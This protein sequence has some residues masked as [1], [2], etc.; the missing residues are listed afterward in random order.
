MSKPVLYSYFR[1]SSAWRVRIALAYKGIDYEYRPVHL[2]KDGGQQNMEE[3][4]ILNPMAQV[5]T[6]IID[7]ITLTQ[8]VPIIEYLDETRPQNKLLPEDPAQRAKVRAIAEMINS[9][10]QPLQNLRVLNKLLILYTYLPLLAIEKVLQHT[11][12]RFCV[13]DQLTLADV[14][15]IP[16]IYGANRFKVDMSEF[17]TICKVNEELEKMDAVKAADAFIQPDCPEELRKK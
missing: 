5:P 17:P 8:S 10:I 11:A 16:Q 3:Y 2:V 9:G 4:M 14:C 1:S 13:G 7:G 6:L 12:G 15:L